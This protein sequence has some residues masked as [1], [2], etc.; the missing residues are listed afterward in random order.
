MVILRGAKR[1][2]DVSAPAARCKRHDFARPV[3]LAAGNIASAQI[4]WS[5]SPPEIGGTACDGY[6]RLRP[7]PRFSASQP[8]ARM[9]SPRSFDPSAPSPSST[10]P[11]ASR[12]RSPGRSRRRIPISLSFRIGGKLTERLVSIDDQVTPGESSP[13]SIR[14]T[15]RASFAPRRPILRRPS[16]TLRSRKADEVRQA[17]LLRKNVIAQAR[18]DQA[19]AGVADG[20]LAGRTR[21][22]RGRSPRATRSAMPSFMPT[23]PA[24][25]RQPALRPAKSS[26][27]DR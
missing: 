6:S 22:R 14:R 16:A 11:L 12:Y 18:Y 17:E 2:K 26:P 25:S 8:A 15:W 10:S 9:P 4:F 1:S 7:G 27:P 13:A 5:I 23:A 24:P 3:T 20:A 19:A 21:R